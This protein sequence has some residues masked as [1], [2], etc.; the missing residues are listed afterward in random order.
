MSTINSREDVKEALEKIGIKSGRVYHR[1]LIE[2]LEQNLQQ[3]YFSHGKYGVKIKTTVE[4][5]ENNR[6]NADIKISEGLAALIKQINIEGTPE[7][8]G[9]M[10]N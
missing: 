5:L 6:V 1:S 8:L 9:V 7:P 3:V 2:V 4:E 10:S